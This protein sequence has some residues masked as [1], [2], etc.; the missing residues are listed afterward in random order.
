MGTEQLVGPRARVTKS[1]NRDKGPGL[2][3]SSQMELARLALSPGANRDTPD[4]GL[5]SKV[6]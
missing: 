5:I 3:D 1:R 6:L 2:V 4:A